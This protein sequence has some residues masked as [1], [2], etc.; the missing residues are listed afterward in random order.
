M[1]T[2]RLHWAC[3]T[4]TSTEAILKCGGAQISTLTFFTRPPPF[5]SGLAVEVAHLEWHPKNSLQH[6]CTQ[7]C[8]QYS[9]SEVWPWL[10]DLPLVCALVPSQI[11]MWRART[12]RI[13]WCRCKWRLFS[14][15]LQIHQ[16]YRSTDVATQFSWYRYDVRSAAATCLYRTRF[17]TLVIWNSVLSKRELT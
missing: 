9:D 2:R 16:F 11:K 7:L 4:V 10:T 6:F 17:E 15:C 14:F 3:E 8:A 12:T 5:C 13:P 1:K